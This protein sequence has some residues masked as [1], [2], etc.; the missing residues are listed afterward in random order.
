MFIFPILNCDCF[1]IHVSLP[2][3]FVPHVFNQ[4]S[5]PRQSIAPQ[6]SAARC[7]S[8]HRPPHGT[9]RP[10]Q[11]P[12]AVQPAYPPGSSFICFKVRQKTHVL[13]N[14]FWA[15]G[16]RNQLVFCCSNSNRWILGCHDRCLS[17]SP[18][19]SPSHLA[20]SCPRGRVGR[21]C[22]APGSTLAPPKK[23]S[24][25]ISSNEMVSYIN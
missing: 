24:A 13:K 3:G 18:R 8:G 10:S 5:L 21:D 16:L 2:H 9:Q 11:G 6:R 20:R 22:S 19:R 23:A 17:P 4:L 25:R 15:Q 12:L 14:R 1:N 7:R